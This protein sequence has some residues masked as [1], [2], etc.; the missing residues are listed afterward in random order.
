MKNLT[1]ILAAAVLCGATA[2]GDEFFEAFRNPPDATKPGVYWYW[3]R[4][5]ISKEGVT[6]IWKR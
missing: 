2:Q 4:N 3:L 5:N 6:K 1:A